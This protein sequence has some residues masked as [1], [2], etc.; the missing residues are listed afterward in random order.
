MTSPVPE[1]Q[2]PGSRIMNKERFFLDTIRAARVGWRCPYD[3]AFQAG[4]GFRRVWHSV[5]RSNCRFL[6]IVVA[7]NAPGRFRRDASVWRL[8][9]DYWPIWYLG[10]R[11]DRSRVLF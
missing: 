5:A 4:P 9:A 6:F 7:Q 8:S 11:A 10:A 1:E 3:K 2:S